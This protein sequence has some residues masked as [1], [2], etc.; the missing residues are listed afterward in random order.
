MIKLVKKAPLVGAFFVSA[1][2]VPGVSTLALADA[3]CIAPP[4][5]PGVQVRNVVDGDTVKL[6]DGR[7]VRLIGLNAPELA[8]QGRSEEPF[9][10]AARQRLQA[11]VS[12][13]QGRVLMQPGR[14]ARDK[15]GRTLAHLYAA[16]GSNLEAQ[17]LRDGLALQIAIAPNTDL[18]ACHQQ[19]ERQAR[20]AGLG[21]WRRTPLIAA[22]QLRQSGF[23]L[24][25]GRVGQV[26]RNRG[27]TWIALGDS[28][29][30][31]IAPKDES[32]FSAALLASY[33][34]QL[35]EAR[36]WVLDRSRRGGLRPGQARWML[37]VSD[38]SMLQRAL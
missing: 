18:V 5:L 20:A 2:L 10:V 36:G 27:G 7:S 17:L 22:G 21:V 11:L 28:L 4:G 26:Q 31:H 9:A 30:V 29:V 16:D 35:L 33:Q 13:S 19:A 25:S 12:A 3:A 1:F 15:Y 24:V 8:H 32:R 34:G 14:E 23:A 6:Q 37:A 38:P